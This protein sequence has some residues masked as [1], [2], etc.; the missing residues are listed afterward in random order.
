MKACEPDSAGAPS[1]DDMLSARAE[2][3]RSNAAAS[4]GATRHEQ[5]RADDDRGRFEA[6]SRTDADG[7]GMLGKIETAFDN[8]QREMV[9][10]SFPSADCAHGG[11]RIN[12]RL[13]GR[14][15]TLP[16][17]A[18][19]FLEFWHTA[20]QAGGFGFGARVVD[21]PAG[22][23]GHVGLFVTWPQ[24]RAGSG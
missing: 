17:G 13:P 21:F 10:V 16:A 1:L 19:L 23:P 24:N 3:E 22:V 9:L 6:R 12:N 18:H 5:Q 7:R 2:R 14:Q 8:G 11:R 15:D 4:V 20:L